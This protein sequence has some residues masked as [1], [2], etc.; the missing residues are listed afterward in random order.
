MSS[1][2]HPTTG[3]NSTA[4]QDS[5]RFTKDILYISSGA[6][7]ICQ[8]PLLRSIFDKFFLPVSLQNRSS[9]FGMSSGCTSVIVFNFRKSTHTLLQPT[10]FFTVTIGDAYGDVDGITTP[11]SS[12]LSN[13]TTFLLSWHTAKGMAY[14]LLAYR[15]SI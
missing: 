4:H 6:A 13:P 7:G 15:Q 9:A 14:I 10:F 8:Y 3:M 2:L 1:I 5:K 11:I 12:I